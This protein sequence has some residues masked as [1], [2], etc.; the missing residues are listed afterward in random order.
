M[1]CPLFFLAFL[2]TTSLFSQP[3]ISPE[4]HSDG[5]VTFR[6]KA[7]NAEAVRV[8]CESLKSADMKKD[9]QGVWS[10]TSEPMEP[11][12]YG[13]S[14]FVDSA[15]VIDPSNPLF[16]Y[17]LLNTESQVHVR[18]PASLAWEVN[19][20]PHGQLHRHFYKSRIA[21]DDREFIVYTPPGYDPNAKTGYPVLYL[22]HGFSD[23]ASGWTSAGFANVIFDNL[24][25]RKEAKPMIVVMPLGYGIMDYV[26]GGWDAARR[27]EMRQLNTE[28]FQGALLNEVLPMV[29]KSYRIS[30]DQKT[31]AIAGLSMGGAQSLTVGLNNLDRFAWIGAFSSGGVSTNYLSQFPHLDKKANEKIRLLWIGCGK[32]DGLFAG[33]KKFE[34]WLTSEGVKHIW[35]ESPG[36]H[37]W[38]VWR[39]YLA[40]FTPLLFQDKK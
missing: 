21:E 15:R 19:D 35:K 28:R 2:C 14:F 30:A 10:F 9:G 34:E 8:Q 5:R 40:E 13:Y 6:L 17:N 26:R 18:G 39:R 16:K 11:D 29:E 27:G 23:D 37:S 22:L 1:K 20:V 25:A 24:I 38:R 12:Y 32:E 31:R 33:N 4:V 7:P 36:A 3:I